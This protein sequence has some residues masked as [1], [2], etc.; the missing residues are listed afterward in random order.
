MPSVLKEL[1]EL[2]LFQ[3]G[4]AKFGIPCLFVGVPLPDDNQ[5][6]GWIAISAFLAFWVEGA[7]CRRYLSRASLETKSV[8]VSKRPHT[9]DASFILTPYPSRTLNS[10][11]EDM[12]EHPYQK[13]TLPKSRNDNHPPFI[14][15]FNFLTTNDSRH[16]RPA[17][18]AITYDFLMG[19]SW[20]RI[21]RI[22]PT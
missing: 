21:L 15:N 13:R 11:E 20:K 10:Q 5:T 4:I 6:C 16:S 7:I 18:T 8:A 14:E 17:V 22:V 3:Y 12:G 1:T 9:A 2:E 19:G